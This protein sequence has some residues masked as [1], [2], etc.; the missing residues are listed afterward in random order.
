MWVDSRHTWP[1]QRD[2]MNWQ[3]AQLS[4]CVRKARRAMLASRSTGAADA[5]L[6]F[7]SQ[8]FKVGCFTDLTLFHGEQWLLLSLTPS[9]LHLSLS[10]TN[11]P[12]RSCQA[13][14]TTSRPP[15][16]LL[17]SLTGAFQLHLQLQI[18]TS[19]FLRKLMEGEFGTNVCLIAFQWEYT[20]LYSNYIL[21]WW[22]ATCCVYLPVGL[23]FTADM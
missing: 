18:G 10:G 4:F 19:W 13:S 22:T 1:F 6:S 11:S 20:Q 12:W 9:C 15:G 21:T 16:L 23:F 14:I 2:E 5:G 17:D 3:W 7:S 8:L